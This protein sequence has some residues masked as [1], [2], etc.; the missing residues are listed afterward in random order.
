MY[1]RKSDIIVSSFIIK[2]RLDI[3]RTYRRHFDIGPYPLNLEF[4]RFILVYV[5]IKYYE[6]L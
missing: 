2:V 4:V 1:T 3:L 5:N 6:Y